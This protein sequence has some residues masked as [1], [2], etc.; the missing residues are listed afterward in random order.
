MMSREQLEEFHSEVS[1][2]TWAVTISISLFNKFVIV[3]FSKIEEKF[4]E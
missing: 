3:G 2:D 1:G 4:V